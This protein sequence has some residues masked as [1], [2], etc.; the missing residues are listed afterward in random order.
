VNK[1]GLTDAQMRDFRAEFEREMASKTVQNRPEKRV[2]EGKIELR[3]AKNGSG[4]GNLVGYAAKYNKLSQDLGG[5]FEKLAP[6]CFNSVMEDDVCCLRNHADDNLLG[7]TLSGT[8]GLM[9]D[10]VG[11]K[12]ECE[13][14]DTTCGRD[15]A[16]MIRRGDMRGSSFSFNIAMDGQEWDWDGP[17]PMRTITKIGRLYD[18]S[19]VTNPAY[20]DT[21][22]DMRSF[23]SALEQRNALAAEIV[24]RSVSM[25]HARARLLLARASYF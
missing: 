23:H 3:A 25:S 6:G 10:D 22:V 4:P 24:R 9:L 20:L 12:Y 15:T 7:R 13:L 21:E 19:P 8:V 16:E 2:F 17:R 18:V 1:Y 5:F 14:P 11:L